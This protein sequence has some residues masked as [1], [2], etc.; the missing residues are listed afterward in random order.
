M[1]NGPERPPIVWHLDADQIEPVENSPPDRLTCIRKIMLEY[2]EQRGQDLDKTLKDIRRVCKS[3][4]ITVDPC[5]P[6][7]ESES[8]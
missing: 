3:K 8:S 4:D 2:E 1:P 5:P 6:R 7:E